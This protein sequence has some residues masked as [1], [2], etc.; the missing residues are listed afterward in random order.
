[1]LPTN[2]VARV[3]I[4]V[5]NDCP[6]ANRYCPTI[7]HLRQQYAPRGVA[8]WLVHSDPEETADS[9]RRH[10]LEYKLTLPTLLDPHQLWARRARTD[11][12]PSAAVF[13]MKGELLY[14]GR[15]D[16]RFAEI[17]RERPAPTRHDLEEALNAILAHHS[18][19]VRATKSIGCYIPN[20][21]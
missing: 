12:V 18:I 16:D 21:Q 13:G 17:G 1:M 2:L 10:D 7:S 9:I 3:L 4:F 15:I 14:H 11:T 5:S 19:Q 6:L 8:F 20:L